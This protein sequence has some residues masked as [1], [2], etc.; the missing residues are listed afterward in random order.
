[1]PSIALGQGSGAVAKASPAAVGTLF[2]AIAGAAALLVLRWKKAAKNAPPVFNMGLPFI[3]GMIQFL[4]DPLVLLAKGRE[5]HGDCFQ[6][7]LLAKQMICLVG[8]E[9]HEFFFTMD[10]YLDQAKMYAF[11]IPVFGRRVLYDVDYSRRM[12]QIRFI[13]ERLTPE[14][15]VSYTGTLDGEV[16]KFFE[17]EWQGDEGIRDIRAAMIECLSRTSVCCLMGKEMRAKLNSEVVPGRTVSDLLHDLEQGM[18]PLSVFMPSA[19]VPRHRRRDEARQLLQEFFEP[20]L[21][22]R[23]KLADEMAGIDFL[24]K[25]LTS[26]YPDGSSATDEEVVG[27]LIAAFFGGM[28]NSSITTSW[29]TLEIF[30]RPE[31]VEELKAEQAAAL[32]GLD[33]SLPFTYEAYEAMPK[34]RSAVMET[35][36]LHPPLMLLMRTVEEDVNFKNYTIPRGSMVAVSPTVA[37]TLPELFPN[38]EIFE[39]KR[40][41]N[42]PPNQFSFIGFG[43]GR[44]I[45]KGQEFG[46]L[47]IMAVISKLMRLYEIETLDGVTKPTIGEGMVIAPS[48]PCRVRY[49]RRPIFRNAK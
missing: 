42:E 28:H 6:V 47:Q 18:L 29:S 43:A 19:P 27:F 11:T 48:Q 41:L 38:P 35:L 17:Q 10:K 14:S 44:R 16:A 7:S 39:P 9:G 33:P 46:Y 36:R 31:L 32:G 30:S 34:L 2:C 21:A 45:C 12:C 24:Q 22:T 40:F 13:R 4:K 3:G 15:L 8:E 1:M 26:T 23:R 25:V 5:K 20:V 37:G 49:T